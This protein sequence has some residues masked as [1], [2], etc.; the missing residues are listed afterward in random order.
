MT[1]DSLERLIWEERDGEITAGDRERLSELARQRPEAENVRRQ[2]DE[3]DRIL[4]AAA[5]AEAPAGLEESIRQAIRSR[6]ALVARPDL[7]VRRRLPVWAAHAAVLAAGLALGALAYHMVLLERPMGGDR[8][9]AGSIATVQ[10]LEGSRHLQ[11]D[12]L[13]DV[14]VAQAGGVI[15]LE[16]EPTVDRPVRLELT[17]AGGELTLLRLTSAKADVWLVEQGPAIV[18]EAARGG[19]YRLEL[20]V[21]VG[22]WPLHLEVASAGVP[23]AT[24]EIRRGEVPHVSAG[25]TNSTG[26]PV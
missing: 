7:R 13:A 20:R 4:A 11:L 14:A 22:A 15:V 2:V 23:T 10:P 3:L 5:D 17:A 21:Q 25:T 16:V 9:F 1:D 24:L 6:P 12:G 19:S 26:P 18:L 8:D